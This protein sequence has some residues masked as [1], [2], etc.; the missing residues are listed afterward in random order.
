MPCAYQKVNLS[1]N[2]HGSTPDLN[3]MGAVICSLV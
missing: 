2:A 3:G 1:A